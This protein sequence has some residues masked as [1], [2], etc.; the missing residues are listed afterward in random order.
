MAMVQ[1][2][3]I[4]EHLLQTHPKLFVLFFNYEQLV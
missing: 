4:D 1:K 2:T 3:S